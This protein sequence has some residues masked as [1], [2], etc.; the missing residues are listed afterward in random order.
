M[1]L[2]SLMCGFLSC[3][4]CTVSSVILEKLSFRLLPDSGKNCTRQIV[5]RR[6]EVVLYKICVGFLQIYIG[7]ERIYIKIIILVNRFEF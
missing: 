2:S 5:M 1:H 4:E 6:P 3:Q 7:Y